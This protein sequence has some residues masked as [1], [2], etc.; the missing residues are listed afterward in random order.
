MR[1]LAR[2]A[3]SCGETVA[4]SSRRLRPCVQRSA[5]I[6]CRRVPLTRATL[7]AC[8]GTTPARCRRV[9]CFSRAS[10]ARFQIFHCAGAPCRNAFGAGAR[11]RGPVSEKAKP[12][13]AATVV[14]AARCAE[15]KGFEVFL[16]RRPDGMPFLGGMYCFPGGAVTKEDSAPRMIERCRGRTADQARK[17]AGAQFSPRQA[18]GFWIAAVR[19]LFEEV[20]V[21]LAVDAS[22]KRVDEGTQSGLLKSI[23]RC[24]ISL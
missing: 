1:Y 11:T 20:G 8:T 15:P 19:E 3:K 13:Q 18:L 2:L 17:I 22:G 21:L 14:L 23:G 7:S 6:R 5:I 24:S 9:S 4:Q 16:T 12:R 10:S